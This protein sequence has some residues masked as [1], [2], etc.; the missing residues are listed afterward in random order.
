MP[1]LCTKKRLALQRRQWVLLADKHHRPAQV[2]QVI[3]VDGVKTGANVGVFTAG[4]C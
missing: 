1:L 4:T 3:G 2:F